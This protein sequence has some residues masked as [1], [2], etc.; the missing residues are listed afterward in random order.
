MKVLVMGGTQFNGLALVRELMRTGHDV[1]ILNRGQTDAP[2]PRGVKRLYA[3]R[4]DHDAMRQVLGGQEFDCIHDVS[5]YRPE[6]V[7]LMVE[8]FRGRVGHYIFASS[9]V[10]YEP[11][12]VL[13]I[14]EDFPLDRSPNQI[15]YGMNK[16]LCEDYLVEQ[17]REHGFPMTIAAFSMVFGPRN[18]I[19]DR[20][21][22]MFMRILKGRKVM[23]P[24]DGTTLGQVGHVDDQ[25][26]ALRLLMANP[27]ALGRR[28]NI[29]AIGVL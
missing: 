19:P 16:I 29:H 4:T 6:D 14:T 11:S 23:I 9:T 25:A 10:I 1:T 8:L 7:Q 5:A 27:K 15:E 17:Y 18:I 21:Q 20:E 24:G 12:N 2:L 22:R 26:R 13:P 28:Y 3:D